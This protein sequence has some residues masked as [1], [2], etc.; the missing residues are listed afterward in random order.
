MALHLF[1]TPVQ[2][3]HC[4]TVVDDPMKDHCPRCGELLKERRAPRRLAGLEE[5]YRSMRLLLSALRFLA[6]MVM[7]IGGIA[8]FGVLG[9]PSAGAFQG[10]IILVG[11]VVVAVALFATA[12][13]FELAMD[14]E[15]N[16]RAS[17]RL[18]QMILEELQ[19]TGTQEEALPGAPEPATAPVGGA[20]LSAVTPA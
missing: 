16:T 8:F 5:R 11:A 13:F 12:A 1:S 17:F 15:E 14:L 10:V 2:C 6:V 4:G 19:E 18:Q 20:P 3:T 7:V 9:N